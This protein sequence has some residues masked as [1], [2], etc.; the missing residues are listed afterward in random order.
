MRHLQSVTIGYFRL[1][2]KSKKIA[3]TLANAEFTL[4]KSN[5]RAGIRTP[6]NLIKSQGFKPLL[7]L[8]Y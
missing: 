5:E 7:T 2:E 1:H 4:L 3:Q 8:L 6:D